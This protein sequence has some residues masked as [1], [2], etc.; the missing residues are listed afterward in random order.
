MRHRTTQSALILAGA[1]AGVAAATW[2]G[3]RRLTA[4]NT[5]NEALI[6]P[7]GAE[8]PCRAQR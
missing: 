2:L 5:S 7:E 3:K 1:A 8:L 4:V 6:E